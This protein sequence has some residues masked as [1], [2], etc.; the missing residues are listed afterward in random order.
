M[1]SRISMLGL[2]SMFL[3]SSA[4]KS[5]LADAVE[6]GDSGKVLYLLGTSF[7]RDGNVDNVAS[8]PNERIDGKPLLTVAVEKGDIS[9]VRTLSI[10]SGMDASATDG[11]GM[12]PLHVAAMRCNA[13]IAIALLEARA[14]PNAEAPRRKFFHTNPISTPLEGAVKCQN[15]AMFAALVRYKVDKGWK[16]DLGALSA[17]AERCTS[18]AYDPRYA[19]VLLVAE[20]D[21][22][23]KLNDTQMGEIKRCSTVLLGAASRG[24]AI[25]DDL[26]RAR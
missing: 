17:S 7:S 19:L 6:K 20:M 23:A 2:L 13:E 10:T 21:N 14:D 9:I 22:G 3:A 18:T 11:W 5:R 26:V 24:K 4:C 15:W 16:T 1:N 12:S 8:D 25:F